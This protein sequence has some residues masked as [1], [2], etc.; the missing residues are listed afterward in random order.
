MTI[1]GR[2]LT[3]V[4]C[5]SL[6]PIAVITVIY[7]LSARNTLEKQTLDLM[8]A[9]AESRK[10]NVLSFLEAKRGR[11]IDFS[12][13]GF[14][15]DSLEQI[16][17]GGGTRTVADLNKH[18]LVNKRPLDPYVVAIAVLDQDGKVVASTHGAW[19]GEDMSNH[20]VFMQTAGKNN[21]EAYISRPCYSPLLGINS[22]YV[23][24]PLISRVNGEKLGVIVNAY[25]LASLDEITTNRAGVGETG[26]VLLGQRSGDNITLLS[27][28]RYAPDAPLRLS[29][30]L[31]S[32]AAELVGLALKQDNGVTIAPDYRN[33]DVVAAY[34]YLPSVDWGLVTKMDK[35]EAFASIKLMSVVALITG[36]VAAAV[37]AGMGILFVISEVR[38]VNRLKNATIRL[39]GG[40]L[41]HRVEITRRD[42]IGDLAGNF[43]IMAKQLENHVAKYE[44][45]AR[46]L[47][48]ANKELEAFCYTVAHDLRSPL[49]SIGGFGQILE[50]EYSDKLDEE[51]RDYLLR[52]RA[53]CRDMEKLIR[54]LLTLSRI[55][56]SGM[57]HE[58]VDL[59]A[60]AKEIIAK[61][62]KTRPKRK[63]EF[64]VK[65]GLVVS[66]DT[67]LLEVV[68]D[69]LLRNAW[70]F[71]GKRP[72]ARIEFS[73]EL[74]D[75]R[76][77]YFVRDN[78]AGFDMAYADK[79]FLPFQRL[80][81][82]AEFEGHGIGLATVQRIIS[83]HG[84]HI[85]AEGAVNQGAA[86]YFTLRSAK[87]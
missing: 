70:K 39:A 28:L 62:Q 78:G 42:E 51:G 37:A 57:K 74:R 3:F 35:A 36:L 2:L 23:S 18:L 54:G 82:M 73:A 32:P 8:T 84:G 19:I 6:I 48:A 81:S 1:K 43:N 26:E 44:Q 75:G 71:T 68:M 7:Y 53:A 77:V 24:A 79:L 55:T 9:V 11:T 86:F 72:D 13:D 25:D 17:H 67:F 52:I 21:N 41:K 85:W 20:D 69:N 59:S 15:R 87:E 10:I 5:V 4:L 29:I 31:D 16:I 45:M 33:V 40:D 64:V 56:R 65:E 14:I 34:E 22:I 49:V 12:S 83:R 61:L 50:K 63:V 47:S 46:D 27:S 38:P 30:P 80:H 76:L 58:T 60:M 66:G